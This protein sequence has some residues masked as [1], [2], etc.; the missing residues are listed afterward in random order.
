MLPGFIASDSSDLQE[1]DTEQLPVNLNLRELLAMAP[2]VLNRGAGGK[3]ATGPSGGNRLP[4]YVGDHRGGK[5]PLPLL[6]KLRAL[7]GQSPFR[8]HAWD[9]DAH[10]RPARPREGGAWFRENGW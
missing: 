8:C 7:A 10:V 5:I 3:P 1:R 9:P 6:P 2:G 4:P